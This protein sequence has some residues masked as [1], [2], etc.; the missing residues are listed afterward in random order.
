MNKKLTTL[1]LV[2]IPFCII[3]F[4]IYSWVCLHSGLGDLF[5]TTKTFGILIIFF[6][7]LTLFDNYLILKWQ[8]Q[9]N[10]LSILLIF[11]QTII[12]YLIIFF[13]Y[14]HTRFY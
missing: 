11:S 10:A 7:L 14:A 6:T 1:L 4:Y 5:F 13:L 2:N 3:F 12:I 9:L 8:K